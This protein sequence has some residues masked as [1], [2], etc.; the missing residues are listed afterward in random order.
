MCAPGQS[1]AGAPAFSVVTTVQHLIGIAQRGLA[2]RAA[3][4]LGSHRFVGTAGQRA[5]TAGAAPAA[6][7]RSN[8]LGLHAW[9][10]PAGSASDPSTAAGRA[11]V[12]GRDQGRLSMET[13]HEVGSSNMFAESL[14]TSA[15]RS[16][17]RRWSRPGGPCRSRI[18]R[19]RK[20]TQAEAGRRLGTTQAQGSALLRCRKVSVAV[21]RLTAFLTAL[22]QDVEETVNPPGTT[23]RGTCGHR[24]AWLTAATGD[25]ARLDGNHLSQGESQ[26]AQ[27]AKVLARSLCDEPE[28]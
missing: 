4:W 23:A 5:A 17:N 21:G 3:S 18:L 15:R 26:P 13:T 20:L 24:A 22:G 2:M 7:A 12:C 10:S 25:G 8:R 19:G 16:P 9:L 6:C 11:G 27:Q 14:P 1:K 28:R